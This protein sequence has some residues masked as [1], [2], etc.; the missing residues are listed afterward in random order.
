MNKQSLYCLLILLSVP[1]NDIV[2]NCN[3]IR[4]DR[5][6]MLTQGYTRLFK[7]KQHFYV[8]IIHCYTINNNT[9]VEESECNCSK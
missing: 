1:V 8:V 7:V 9:T 4:N 5:A 6:P 3:C 2:G